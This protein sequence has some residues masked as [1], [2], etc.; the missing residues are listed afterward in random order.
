MKANKQE[1]N[2]IQSQTLGIEITSN[3]KASTLMRMAA[4]NKADIQIEGL[5]ERGAIGMIVAPAKA[6]KTMLATNLALSLITKVPFL[7]RAIS[8]A[9]EKVLYANLELTP[10]AFGARLNSMD[11]RY[12]FKACADNLVIVNRQELT[13]GMDL[14]DIKEKKVTKTLFDALIQTVLN[15]QITTV[16]IDPLYIVVGE[17]N[18]NVMMTAV[19][20]EFERIRTQTSA[21][22]IIVHHTGKGAVDW[23]EPFLAGRGASSLGGA[24][25]FVLG[26]EP[27]GESGKAIIHHGARNLESCKPITAYFNTETLTWDNER[28]ISADKQLDFIMGEYDELPMKTAEAKSKFNARSIHALIK[29]SKNYVHLR[30]CKGRESTI[31]RTIK[32][33][34]LPAT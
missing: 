26:I 17:E 16:I 23:N 12:D 9:R 2:S 15:E 10:V 5:F 3:N 19:C 14:V 21:T 31:K 11:L 1:E 4:K 25:E 18:D 33:K 22:V 13:N 27:K 32:Q 8:P 29:R 20:R 30:S 7:G 24:I 6:K 28:E 34:P